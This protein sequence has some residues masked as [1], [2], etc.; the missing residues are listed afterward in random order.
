MG[1]MNNMKVYLEDNAININI[2]REVKNQF[3]LAKRK[4]DA[5]IS[6][7]I[8]ENHVT[9]VIVNKGLYDGFDIDDDQLI[10]STTIGTTVD[11]NYWLERGELTLPEIV[12]T[13]IE[14]Y[15]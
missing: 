13:M 5:D 15:L 4:K 11:C 8:N 12:C 6:I 9:L 2:L 10:E 3:S 1:N 14:G 7:S